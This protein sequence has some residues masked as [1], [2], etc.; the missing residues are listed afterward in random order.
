MS[1]LLK[2]HLHKLEVDMDP[3]RHLVGD[4]MIY[5]DL[6]KLY[7]DDVTDYI[8][9]LEKYV[10]DVRKLLTLVNDKTTM[11]RVVRRRDKES[12]LRAVPTHGL[13]GYM[14]GGLKVH[15]NKNDP[16]H[17]WEHFNNVLLTAL[18]LDRKSRYSFNA[19]DS[20]AYLHDLMAYSRHNH[21]EL[22][23]DFVLSM[24]DEDR[25]KYNPTNVDW[26][27]VAWACLQHRASFDGSFENGFSELMN[28]SDRE[29][30]LN[31]HDMVYRSINFKKD[32]VVKGIPDDATV[33]RVLDHLKDKFG[34]GGYARFPKVYTDVFGEELERQ[35]KIVDKFTEDEIRRL[36]NDPTPTPELLGLKLKAISKQLQIMGVEL[37]PIRM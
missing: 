4:V 6:N 19:I 31:L 21:H 23:R 33:E 27:M 12:I 11:T 17:G 36:Y 18:L 22:S 16:S 26:D 30:P 1:K 5:M 13:I 34:T 35:S 24:S 10:P 8:H 14:Y 32:D 2:R 3:I 9:I 25:I 20:A 7:L 29:L 15:Y 28:A 37:V